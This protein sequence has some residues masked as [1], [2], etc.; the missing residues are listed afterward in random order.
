LEE[1]QA[2]EVE[3]DEEICMAE[4]EESCWMMSVEMDY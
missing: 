3:T 1:E 4:F 2:L